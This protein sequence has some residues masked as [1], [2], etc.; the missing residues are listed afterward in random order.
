MEPTAKSEARRLRREI[1]ERC[2]AENTAQLDDLR[3]RGKFYMIEYQ[4]PPADEIVRERM[5][6]REILINVYPPEGCFVAIEDESGVLRFGWS[7]WN[8]TLIEKKC[9][10]C[11]TWHL[12][13][14]ER[15][16]YVKPE[17]L[18]R[19]LDRVDG[20]DDLVPNRLLTQ[21]AMFQAKA[22]A[23]FRGRGERLRRSSAYAL[24]Q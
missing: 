18:R 10:R 8:T 5:D 11:R 22:E 12:Q 7:G 14:I 17:G 16:P 4:R 19:A 15:S 6:G 23:E 21:F 9:R 3:R 1:T 13:P 20:S 24:G 2:K